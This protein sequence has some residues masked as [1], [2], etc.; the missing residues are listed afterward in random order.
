MKKILV[1]VAFSFFGVISS[2]QAVTLVGYDL[3]TSTTNKTQN[4]MPAATGVTPSAITAGSGL[5]FLTNNT[6]TSRWQASSFNQT[7]QDDTALGLANTGGDYWAFSVT[8]ASG[9]N[10]TI[11]G[12]GSFQWGIGS[13]GP[14]NMALIY[15]ADSTFSSYTILARGSCLVSSTTNLTATWNAALAAAPVSVPEG[16][17]AYFRIVGYGA[18]STSGT[19]GM[20]ANLP[21]P[22]FSILGDVV[23][24][25]PLFTWTVVQGIGQWVTRQIGK[26]E[27]L[28]LLGKIIRML[29]LVLEEI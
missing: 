11:N 28:P 17:T 12:V 8:A 25:S 24:T 22:D 26:M 7:G 19:G 18:S 9:Y 23:S 4:P 20:L 1:P 10:L 5:S 29:P 21:A 13:S 14:K 2:T 6:S 16:T 15:S 27:E 3:P